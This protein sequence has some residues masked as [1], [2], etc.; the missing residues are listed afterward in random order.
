MNIDAGSPVD[1]SHPLNQDRR[2]WA[3]GASQ[4]GSFADLCRPCVPG[5]GVAPAGF[6]WVPSQYGYAVQFSTSNYIAYGMR[7]VFLKS[8][9]IGTWFRL[10]LREYNNDRLVGK[11]SQASPTTFGS[12][13]CYID[14]Y[15]AA[16]RLK[17]NYNF[18]GYGVTSSGGYLSA[19]S[20][21]RAVGT[22]DHTNGKLSL[23]LNSVLIGTATGGVDSDFEADGNYR[24]GYSSNNLIGE[25]FFAAR[26]WSPGDV[27]MDYDL[28]RRAYQSP[29]SPLRLV[30]A[31]ASVFTGPAPTGN[32]RRRV[33]ICAGGW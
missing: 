3:Y 7:G 5:E 33:I 22:Y 20:W 6:P 31:P 15:D 4:G 16:I 28:S 19:G 12:R 25:T 8:W 18:G 29:N 27:S 32:R 21:Y 11:W 24:I 2:L 26:C 10:K 14:T 23:Y 13:D 1:W 30:G 17:Q 9:T